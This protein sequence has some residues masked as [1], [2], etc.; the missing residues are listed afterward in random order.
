MNVIHTILLVFKRRPW[1]TAGLVALSLLASLVEGAGVSFLV[2]LL[3]SLDTK[4]GLLQDSQITQYFAQAYSRLHLPFAL[5]SVMLGGFIAFSFQAVVRYIQET[6]T[7]RLGG[8]IAAEMRTQLFRNLLSMDLAY[9]HRRRGSEFANSLVTEAN[10]VQ[11]LFVYSVTA[12]ALV[13]ETVV[14]LGIALFLSWSLVLGALGLIAIM[15]PLLRYELKRASRQGDRLTEINEGLQNTAVEHLGGIRILKAF[16]LEGV[17]NKTFKAQ[18]SQMP[19]VNWTAAKSRS[20]LTLVYETVMVA[21]LLL[22]VYYAA[23]FFEMSIPVLLT[24]A[25]ILFRLQPR[26]G[27]M[28]KTLHQISYAIPGAQAVLRL[29]R[30]TQAPSIQSGSKPFQEL[31]DKVR[32][33]GV[34]FGYDGESPVLRDV[35]FTI[36]RGETTA[37]VGRSGAGKTTLA[38]LLMRFYDPSSGRILVDGID[39]KELE[40]DSWRRAIALVSQDVF[41]FND[42]VRSNIAM[43]KPDATE[44]EVIAA[45]RRA[46]ADEFI[47]EFPDGYDTVIG[48]RGVRLSGGQRQRI[49]LARAIVRDPQILIL[50]EAT[51]ELDSKS[52]ELIRQAVEELG[53][54]RTIFIIAHRLSTIRHAD[55]IVVLERGAIVEEGSHEALLKRNGRYAEFLHMQDTV[56]VASN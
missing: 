34:T 6:R 16:N 46:Y 52:E 35:S 2:P 13:M 45:A 3:E 21:S 26:V 1:A 8:E 28:N 30:E 54:S 12:L 31:K 42:T 47:R 48:D 41:L 24:F 44:E 10:R 53:T 11:F 51:S 55:K 25:F 32:F 7:V 19:I 43:G 50:D 39:L 18:A 23:T 38:N 29:L 4:G 27:A 49:A 36:K 9:I 40:L 56:A 5:W 15:T 20:R 22:V 33:E 37:I 17:S 14:Y